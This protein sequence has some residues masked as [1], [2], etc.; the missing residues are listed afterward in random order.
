[1]SKRALAV[2]FLCRKSAGFSKQNYV[3][4][5]GSGG[6]VFVAEERGLN[7]KFQDKRAKNGRVCGRKARTRTHGPKILVCQKFVRLGPTTLAE[8]LS[9]HFYLH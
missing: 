6:L 2:C 5:L 1:M 9:K 7:S 3:F 8:S 4:K